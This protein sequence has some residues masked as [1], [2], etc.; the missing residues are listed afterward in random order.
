MPV[1][2]LVLLTLWWGSCSGKGEQLLRGSGAKER[3]AASQMGWEGTAESHRGCSLTRG[4]GGEPRDGWREGMQ[5]HTSTQSGG[6]QPAPALWVLQQQIPSRTLIS[7]SSHLTLNPSLPL[8]HPSAP[9]PA[10]QFYFSSTWCLAG[11]PLAIQCFS[12]SIPSSPC[13]PANPRPAYP[14]RNQ[15]LSTP[16]KALK[17]SRILKNGSQTEPV[18]TSVTELHPGKSGL[19]HPQP[20]L[21]FGGMFSGSG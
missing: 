7:P 12:C 19:H 20:R 1:T 17:G 9:L 3:T 5:P 14:A 6:H 21:G 11:S 15:S 4:L 18:S 10:L 13:R 8:V 2:S 16:A